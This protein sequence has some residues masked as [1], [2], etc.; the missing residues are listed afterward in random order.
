MTGKLATM[1]ILLQ[2]Q[3]S[4]QSPS[5]QAKSAVADDV[6]SSLSHSFRHFGVISLQRFDVC[7]GK[8]SLSFVKNKLR[9]SVCMQRMH[10]RI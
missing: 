8:I 5:Q 1:P 10:C 4:P 3:L 9:P 6:E 2:A 7:E